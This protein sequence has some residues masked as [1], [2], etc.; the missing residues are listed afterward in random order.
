METTVHNSKNCKGYDIMKI[1]LKTWVLG[2]L[3]FCAAFLIINKP[4]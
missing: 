2:S 4:T 1:G 3:N